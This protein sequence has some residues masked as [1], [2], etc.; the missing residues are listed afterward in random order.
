MNHKFYSFNLVA[1]ALQDLQVILIHN[2]LRLT[3][4]TLPPIHWN[5]SSLTRALSNGAWNSSYEMRKNIHRNLEFSSRCNTPYLLRD[6]TLETEVDWLEGNNLED[7]N[8]SA[9]PFVLS[10]PPGTVSW[11]QEYWYQHFTH[12][13]N[14]F[15]TIKNLICMLY[16]YN[17]I[18]I[19]K[20]IIIKVHHY[21]KSSY[22]SMVHSGS[23]SLLYKQ[24]E[25]NK[26]SR[27]ES[28]LFIFPFI[29]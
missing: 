26:A 3:S 13:D 1:C 4:S 11:L 7:Q 2:H 14:Y 9:F 21:L 12:R 16:Y 22:I 18:L 20:Y 29:L 15:V 17:Y 10:S 25:I 27:F 6:S 19:I 23:E 28:E 24:L 5:R 8:H